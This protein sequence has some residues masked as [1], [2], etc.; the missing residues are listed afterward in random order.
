MSK[1]LQRS[2][3]H[4]GEWHSSCTGRDVFSLVK[5]HHMPLPWN[6][7][8]FLS[9]QN[10]KKVPV[11]LPLDYNNYFVKNNHF[12]FIFSKIKFPL[13]KPGE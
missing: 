11:C 13:T 9:L 10:V 4:L 1:V 2:T 7:P 5:H 12:K 3:G 8:G 6:L